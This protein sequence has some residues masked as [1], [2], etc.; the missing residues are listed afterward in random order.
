M[1]RNAQRAIALVD[2]VPFGD[3]RQDSGPSRL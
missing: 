3:L 1:Y 2:A